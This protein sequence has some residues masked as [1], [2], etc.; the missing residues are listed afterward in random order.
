ME[1]TQWSC[2]KENFETAPQERKEIMTKFKTYK[3]GPHSFRTYFKTVGNGFEVGLNCDGKNYFVGNFIHKNEA[4]RWW[5]TFNREIKT[6]AKKFW[7]SDKVTFSWYC[8][9]LSN[10]LYS[11]YYKFLDKLFYKYNK[12]FHK[13]YNREAKK[14]YKMKKYFDPSDKYYFQPKAA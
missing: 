9:F 4:M 12:S 14:Y 2:G 8:K 5:G 11:C 7:V 10:H 3:Y 6:F 13:A 1:K